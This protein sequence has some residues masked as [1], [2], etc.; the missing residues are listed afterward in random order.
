MMD[1]REF[2]TGF[3]SEGSRD[4]PDAGGVRMGGRSVVPLRAAGDVTL[5]ER[6]RQVL[7]ARL[8]CSGFFPRGVFRDSAWDMMLE[9]FIASQSR[10]SLC[11]KDLMAVANETATG[12]V[13]RINSLEDAKLVSRRSDTD[14]H[15]RVCVELTE[16]GRA[17]M[18]TFLRNL[19]PV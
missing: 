11:V 5:A 8:K 10:Q 17:A 18:E 9:L 15:R 13:R 1:L 19:Y 16:A 14:D 12:A 3:S 7:D 4:V 2:N 6:A